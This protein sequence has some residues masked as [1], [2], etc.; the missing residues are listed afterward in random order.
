MFVKTHTDCRI[1]R[2]GSDL[3]EPSGS[4]F[5]GPRWESIYQIL[6]IDHF[7]SFQIIMVD[8]EHRTHYSTNEC[9][10]DDAIC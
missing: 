3:S 4:N 6:D 2:K 5:G 9:P 10:A 8:G 1:K 7:P